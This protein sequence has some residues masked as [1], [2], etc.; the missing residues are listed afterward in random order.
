MF[1]GE[2]IVADKAGEE[3]DAVILVVDGDRKPQK[4]GSVGLLEVVNDIDAQKLANI[5][6]KSV[7]IDLAGAP[8]SDMVQVGC[9]HI[10]VTNLSSI[11]LF[12]AVPRMSSINLPV[13]GKAHA[14]KQGLKRSALASSILR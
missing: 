2:Y 6:A 9:P 8:G 10:H 11:R 3:E 13:P 4:R 1:A 12:G 14:P 5:A 7:S